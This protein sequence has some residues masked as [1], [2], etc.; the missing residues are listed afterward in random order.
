MEITVMRKLYSCLIILSLYFGFSSIAMAA[1]VHCYKNEKYGVTGKKTV[2]SEQFND[3]C[4]PGW[5]QWS[6]T[7]AT[8]P[9]KKLNAKGHADSQ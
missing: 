1:K 5:K 6:P 9:Q 8:S 3:S 4:P 7:N 2:T